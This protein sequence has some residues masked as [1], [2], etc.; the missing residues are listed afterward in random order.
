MVFASSKLE[1]S[2]NISDPKLIGLFDP[3][4]QNNNIFTTRMKNRLGARSKTYGNIIFMH[5]DKRDGFIP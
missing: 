5:G 1:T 4:E 2:L 3:I